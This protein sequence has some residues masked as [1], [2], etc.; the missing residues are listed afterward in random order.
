MKR[1][2]FA[3]FL[4]IIL[5]SLFLILPHS[6]Y[7]QVP[8]GDWDNLPNHLKGRITLYHS[9]G[10][11]TLLFF[12]HTPEVWQKFMGDNWDEAKDQLTGLLE[13]TTEKKPGRNF[14]VLMVGSSGSNNFSFREITFTQGVDRYQ[15]SK[16]NV[17]LSKVESSNRFLQGEVTSDQP[18]AGLLM[19][20]EEIQIDKPFELHYKTRSQSLS[21]KGA[22]F[23]FFSEC[24]D[25][26]GTVEREFNWEGKSLTLSLSRE[27]ICKSQNANVPRI[28]GPSSSTLEALTEVV[29]WNPDDPWMKKIF[30]AINQDVQGYYERADNTIHFV[31][32]V[33]TYTGETPDY[34]QTPY[35]TLNT[36][37]GDCEDGAILLASLLKAG[38][39]KVA[40]GTYPGHAFVWVKVSPDWVDEIEAGVFNKCPMFDIWEI[41]KHGGNTYAMA[42]TAIDP[43]LS[44][45]LG[46]W[47]LGCGQIPQQYWEQGEVKVFPLN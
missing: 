21:T 7:S 27:N 43:E 31:Q 39:Y 38:G 46:Y 33:I 15:L 4:A 42:E 10:N 13:I 30:D 29:K 1:S 28:D 16:S 32:D 9:Q 23:S 25:K 8:E 17:A 36:K 20:P 47:G 5:I 6:T 37:M 40:L 44:T 34:W 12:F 19:L 24:R 2:T 45:T 14:I 18:V 26:I 41:A 22:D 11:L 35:E 3:V